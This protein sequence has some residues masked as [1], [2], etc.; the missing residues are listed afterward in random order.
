MPACRL[1][2]RW[3]FRFVLS[4]WVMMAGAARAEDALPKSVIHI[5]RAKGVIVVDGNLDDGGWQGVVPDTTWYETNVTDNTPPPV[6]TV[7]YLAYDDHYL[8]AAFRLDDPNPS[9]VRGP[10][11]DHDAMREVSKKFPD[12]LDAATLFAESGM[13]LH[14]WGLWHQDGTPQAGTEEIV[15][16]LERPET[17]R[18]EP[19]AGT[20]TAARR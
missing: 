8:Y 10:L 11:G 2:C 4:G 19:S 16:T 17:A 9:G 3:M 18:F 12:D 14:P 20:R 1:V 15:A 6:K 7:G 5:E 13:N